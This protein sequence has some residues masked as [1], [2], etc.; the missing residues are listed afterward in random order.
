M[1]KKPIIIQCAREIHEF[2]GASGV[3]FHLEKE[4][5]KNNYVV[6][7]F[8]IEDLPFGKWMSNKKFK[9]IIIA[10][11]HL[12]F[13]IL[14]YSTIGSLILLFKKNKN[15]IIICHSDILIGDIYINH[16]LHK[17]LLVKNGYI[18]MFLKNP[19][20]LFLYLREE[21][22][23]RFSRH[24]LIVCF[25]KED[26]N[27]LKQYY[28]IKSKIKIIP[29]GIDTT[30]FYFN[31]EI[32]NKYRK[33]NKVSNKFVL[34][35]V[36]HEFERKGLDIIIESLKY[37]DDKVV[38]WVIGGN[39]SLI[40]KYYKLAEKFKVEN[41]VIFF[42]IQQDVNGYINASDAMI[43]ASIIEP[44]GLVG[45]EAMAVGK[46]L[47]STKTHGTKEY[48]EDYF[49][50]L[51]VKREAKDIADKVNILRKKKE[52]Y[53]KLS[54]NARKTAEKYDWKY[55]SKKYINIINKLFKDKRKYD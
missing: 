28:P 4:F 11:V 32:R 1:N 12:F 26:A 29:N 51:F 19:L 16:G 45:L 49:N 39:N 53:L 50:G 9:N 47:I 17:S 35:F 54:K 55:I 22:R 36:G 8:T 6:K 37:L 30:K 25:S 10:K 15:N 23:H 52:L 38:L 14:Y 18:K 2:G 20:H 40:S 13:S 46:P 34:I 48:L 3:A 27:E 5:K 33:I 41:R 42:G 7:R 31:K 44:W 21:F 24:K 43:L